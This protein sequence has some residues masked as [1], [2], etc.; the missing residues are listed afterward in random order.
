VR[1]HGSAKQR[2]PQRAFLPFSPPPVDSRERGFT[3]LCLGARSSVGARFLAPRKCTS[4]LARWS[5][6]PRRCTVR[7]LNH[8]MQQVSIISTSADDWSY[9]HDDYRMHYVAINITE[10]QTAECR[11]G[12]R[13]PGRSCN[14]TICTAFYIW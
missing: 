8:H 6:G 2:Y 13:S 12:M 4:E 11:T 5:T 9:C 14:A 10:K 3:R 1:G 7:G